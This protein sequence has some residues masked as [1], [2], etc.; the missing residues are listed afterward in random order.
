MAVRKK[1][2]TINL[3]VS[4]ESKNL[5]EGMSNVLG[6][7]ATQIIEE[8][9]VAAAKSVQLKKL[10]DI[11][12]AESLKGE[13]LDLPTV[14]EAAYVE[15]DP[16]LTKLRM[17]Y[18]A[19]GAVSERDKLI[20]SAIVESLDM[21]SGPSELF[22]GEDIPLASSF[23][24]MTPTLDFHKIHNKWEVLEEYAVFRGKN[25]SLKSTFPAFLKL[26]DRD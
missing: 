26:T 17:F 9:I 15:G 21:F 12:D 25:K 7:T 3:R 11:V 13:G 6:K 5:L 1:S 24:S 22:A 10:G 16:V 23:R 19:P 14:V 18:I 2:E 8:L 20:V 4:P